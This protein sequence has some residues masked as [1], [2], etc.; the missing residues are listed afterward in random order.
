MVIYII[1]TYLSCSTG[2]DTAAN[3]PPDVA[4]PDEPG[5]WVVGHRA[6]V[7]DDVGEVGRSVPVDVWYPVTPGDEAGSET[8]KYAL[9]GEIGIVSPLAHEGPPGASGAAP[10]LIFS[11]GYNS[12]NVQSSSLVE[13]LASHGFVVAAPAHTGN[14]QDAPDDD[15]ETA[16]SRRVPDVAAVLDWFVSGAAPLADQVDTDTVGVLGH[17]FGGMTTLGAG[18]GWAGA[19]PIDGVDA[20]MPISAVVDAELQQ[21]DRPY[22]S[23]GFTEDALASIAQPV[24]LL[25]GTKDLNV[26]VENNALAYDW[27][28]GAQQVIRADIIGANHTHFTNVCDIGALLLEYG[29]EMSVWPTVGAADLIAPYTDTCTG[30]ALPI[31]EAI[32]LQNLLAV[33]FFRLHLSGEADYAWWLEPQAA[34]RETA[35]TIWAR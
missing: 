17:S 26:P 4:P 27:L 1:L 3:T 11:H 19:P 20:L 9:L 13:A 30:D 35:L 10:L 7:L 15:F 32:R 2:T 18:A 23:A 31:A 14:T 24:L 8:T 6:T 22:P 16:A 34:E 33:A 29:I 28:T 12:I 21:D 5:P 25:G